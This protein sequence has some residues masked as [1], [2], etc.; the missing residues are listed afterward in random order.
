MKIFQTIIAA[1]LIFITGIIVGGMIF[2]DAYDTNQ[3]K[4]CP[5]CGRRYYSGV[6]YCSYC[7][8]ELKEI[9]K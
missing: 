5:D 8:T 9:Q 7:G 4:F 2:L 6:T 3:A 1:T